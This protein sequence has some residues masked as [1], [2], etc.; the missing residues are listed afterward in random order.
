M[1]LVKRKSQI[2]MKLDFRLELDFSLISYFILANYLQVMKQLD[3]EKKIKN[4]IITNQTEVEQIKSDLNILWGQQKDMKS[5]YDK[6]KQQIEQNLVEYQEI[7]KKY[8]LTK[9]CEKNMKQSL[10]DIENIHT[11]YFRIHEKEIQD[12]DQIKN[13]V[14]FH[15]LQL[16]QYNE[17]VINYLEYKIKLIKQLKHIECKYKHGIPLFFIITQRI[18][19]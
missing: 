10:N 5:D 4:Q 15:K 11:D 12:R 17:Q 14:K 7:E 13:N 2:T 3:K 6:L 8:N 1:R 9:G 18:I 19:L 16:K